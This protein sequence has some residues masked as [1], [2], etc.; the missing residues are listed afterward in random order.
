LHQAHQGSQPT[1]V[2]ELDLVELE[3]DIATLLD[4]VSDPRVQGKD[5][6]AGHDPANALNDHDVADGTTLKMKLHHDSSGLRNAT[7]NGAA[8]DGVTEHSANLSGLEPASQ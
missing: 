3:H 5:F 4:G 7:D 1:A 2:D 8:G 6:I